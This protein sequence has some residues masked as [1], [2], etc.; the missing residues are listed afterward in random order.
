G[1][2]A[3]AK[4]PTATSQIWIWDHERAK[5]TMVFERDSP[6]QGSS[7]ERIGKSRNFLL[8]V[9]GE[10]RETEYKVFSLETL[11]TTD[12]AVPKDCSLCTVSDQLELVMWLS[13][14]HKSVLFLNGG[15]FSTLNL[16]FKEE[17]RMIDFTTDG[18]SIL[19]WIKG[20]Q[21]TPV[22][23]WAVNI[24]TG[25]L[26]RGES[27]PA[28]WQVREG[29][30]AL[31]LGYENQGKGIDGAQQFKLYLYQEALETKADV[32]AY[33]VN[34][35]A[36]ITSGV[37][38]ALL[39]DTGTRLAFTSQGSLFVSEILPVTKQFVDENANRESKTQTINRAKMVALAL[40]MYASDMDDVLP[41]TERLQDIMPYLKDQSILNGFVYDYSGERN[42]SK[43]ENPGEMVIGYMPG[44]GGRAVVYIDGH[45]KWVPDKP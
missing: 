37:G 9:F 19:V 13:P 20:Q 6:M 10:N 39:S 22:S 42:M 36:Q 38:R 44:N 34:P 11:R 21:L 25:N 28:R 2:K 26:V 8:S 43:V 16:P 3:N 33:L 12:L 23:D 4:P 41:P 30:T 17:A 24:Q 7:V 27:H 32:P 18:M 1:G 15:K 29:E 45:V 5:S 14:D 31:E 35:H 40:I